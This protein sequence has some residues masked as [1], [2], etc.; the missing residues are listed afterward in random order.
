MTKVSFGSTAKEALEQAM[1]FFKMFPGGIGIVSG[2]CPSHNYIF[3]ETGKELG[4]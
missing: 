2:I 4:C 1:M 3:E